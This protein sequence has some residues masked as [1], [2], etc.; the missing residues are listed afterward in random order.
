MTTQKL[1][2]SAKAVLRGRFIVMQSY[3]KKQGKHQIESLNLHVKQ[4]EKEEQKTPKSVEGR[5]S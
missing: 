4:L 3:L 2:D 1:W 5:R